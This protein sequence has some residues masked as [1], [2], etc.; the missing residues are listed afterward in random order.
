MRLLWQCMDY[1]RS[2]PN[3]EKVRVRSDSGCIIPM[4]I[5][6]RR[7][8]HLGL[9]HQRIYVSIQTYMIIPLPF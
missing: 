8:L 6:K 9:M 3:G 1:S 2:M 4:F 5:V 7:K